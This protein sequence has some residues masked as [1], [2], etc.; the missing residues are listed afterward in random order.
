MKKSIFKRF[1][2]LFMAL[3]I[4]TSSVPVFLAA[5]ED[6]IPNIS[7]DAI[8]IAPAPGNTDDDLVIL[9]ADKND[10]SIT[11]IKTQSKYKITISESEFIFDGKVKTPSV[12]V[13]NPNGKRLKENKDYT[14]KYSAGRKKVGK[15]TVKVTIKNKKAETVKLH[16]YILPSRTAKL[17]FSWAPSAIKAK[18]S[19]VQDANGYRVCLFKDNKLVKK[20]FTKEL[21]C[22]FSSLEK[23]TEYKITVTAFA[24]IDG[25]VMLS[26]V[27]RSAVT[28]T[29][30]EAPKLEKGLPLDTFKV[31]SLKWN[32]QNDA[33]GYIIY[34]S[35][36]KNK[37]FKPVSTLDGRFM[38][39]CL[40]KCEKVDSLSFKIRSYRTVGDEKVLSPFSNTVTF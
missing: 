32:F 23:L 26:P 29:S 7:D 12:T 16:F 11:T 25:S 17:S 33:D 30:T 5:D 36:G 14:V 22:K 1:A 28:A 20:A 31:A 27:S 3:L 38:R 9:P 6:N 21:S 19:K 39:W 2:V 35:E 10:G 13:K 15:Y 40:V 18:W 8:V 34:M 37:P 24:K 4:C